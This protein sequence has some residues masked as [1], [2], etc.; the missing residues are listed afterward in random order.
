MS[1]TVLDAYF[2]V[3]G[4][5]I[6]AVSGISGCNKKRVAQELTNYFDAKFI[7]QFDYYKKN[8]SEIINV[9]GKGNS[10]DIINWDS[11]AA[12]DWDKFNDDV[13]KYAPTSKII[14]LG[15]NL[16]PDLIKFNIDYHVYLNVSKSDCIKKRLA[17]LEKHPEIENDDQ[18]LVSAGLFETKMYNITFPFNEQVVKEMRINKFIKTQDMDAET[19]ADIIWELVKNFLVMTMDNFNKQDYF[20]WTKEHKF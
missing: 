13:Q 9:S 16:K 10:L 6:L 2:K 14:I 20:E 8:Y 17:F 11:D 12:I 19:I 4:Q 15:F 7:D 5:F 18:K 3:Y 1:I